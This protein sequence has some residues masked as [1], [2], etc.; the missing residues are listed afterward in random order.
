ME[1]TRPTIEKSQPYGCN[2][3][4]QTVTWDYD[5]KESLMTKWTPK[6]SKDQEIQILNKYDKKTNKLITNY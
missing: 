2:M 6:A 3:K 5:D 1:G 4:L